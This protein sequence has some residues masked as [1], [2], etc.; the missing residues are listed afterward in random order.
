[1]R[2]DVLVPAHDEEATIAATVASLRAMDWPEECFRV[3]VVADNCSD[4]TVA[5]AKAAGARVIERHQP[6]LRA[7]GMHCN[8]DLPHAWTRG[9]ATRSSS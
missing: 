1:M 6:E 9:R 7:R 3:I 5:R 8:W 4:E 2:F